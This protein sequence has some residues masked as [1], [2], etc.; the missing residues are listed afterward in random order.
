MQADVGAGAL[1]GGFSGQATY[2]ADTVAFSGIQIPYTFSVTGSACIDLNTIGGGQEWVVGDSAQLRIE[3][4]ESAAIWYNF[5]PQAKVRYAYPP[6]NLPGLPNASQIIGEPYRF[7]DGL[8]GVDGVYFSVTLENIGAAFWNVLVPIGAEVTIENSALNA[9]GF[10]YLT[11]EA[12][13]GRVK[14]I[15]NGRGYQDFIAPFTDRT[16]RLVNSSMQ[17]WNFYTFFDN[18]LTISDALY[19][20]SWSF[21]RSTLTIVNSVC[22]GSGGSVSAFDQSEMHVL[23]SYF[24]RAGGEAQILNIQDEAAVYATHSTIEGSISV[25]G[26]SRLVLNNATVTAIP[27]VAS[28]AFVSEARLDSVAGLNAR[29]IARITGQLILTNGP[30]GTAAYTG[31]QIACS[32]PDSTQFKVLLDADLQDTTQVL[33]DYG[34]NTRAVSPGSYLV[35]LIAFV[36]EQMVNRCVVPVQIDPL[37]YTQEPKSEQWRFFPNPVRERLNYQATGVSGVGAIGYLFDGRGQILRRWELAP[38]YGSLDL[39]DLPSGWYAL[40]VF[41][42]RSQESAQERI[43]LLKQ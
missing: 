30:T 40:E 10:T 3:Q 18:R 2:Q 17:A 41:G 24:F 39:R 16:F 34:W 42:A 26:E 19:G 7:D 25:S 5:G 21:D 6:A 23:D 29:Q 27:L 15:E 33:V 35:W 36:D 38:G 28:R 37:T 31:Y 22:D 32:R 12:R 43:L 1:G 14:S 4:A 20:E 13:S 9:A 8:N 11:P